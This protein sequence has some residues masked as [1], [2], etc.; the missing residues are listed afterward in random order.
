M[1]PPGSVW[2]WGQK[3]LMTRTCW[4]GRGPLEESGA[5]QGRGAAV[6]GAEAGEPGG[7]CSPSPYL[8]CD[9]GPETQPLWV[10]FLIHN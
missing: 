2:S 6:G 3:G 10:P 8:F 7:D 9:L 5:P 1:G 4:E